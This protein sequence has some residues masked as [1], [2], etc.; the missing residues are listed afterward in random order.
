MA[1]T[2]RLTL[3]DVQVILGRALIDPRFLQQL[4]TGDVNATVNTLEQ[5]GYELDDAGTE[6]IAQIVRHATFRNAAQ[7]AAQNYDQHADGVIR[8]RCG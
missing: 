5:L 6:M 7:I 1:T 2:N 3:F 8:P 4:A